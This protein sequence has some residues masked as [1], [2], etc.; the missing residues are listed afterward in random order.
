[1]FENYMHLHAAGDSWPDARKRAV[2]LHALGTEGQRLFYALPDT[3]DTYAS[4]VEGLKKHFV[5][6]VNVIAECHKFRQRAQRPEE[7]VNEF[8][9]ALRQLAV[10]CEFGDMEEP[11]LRDQLIERV[12]NTRIRDRLES[13][14]TLAKATTLALQIKTG[15]RNA[16]VLS[17]NTA[18]ATLV[19]AI[20]SQPRNNRPQQK[21]KMAPRTAPDTA[22][23]AVCRRVVTF[24]GR[25]INGEGHT[26]TTNQRNTILNHGK[27]ITVQHMLA[28]LGLTGYSRN[29]VPNYVGLTQPLRDMVSAAGN[30]NLTAA[31]IWTQEAEEAFTNTKQALSTATALAS[32]DYTAPFHLD[33]SEKSGI[34]NAVLYQQKEGERRILMYHSSRLDNMELGQGGCARHLAALAKAITKTEHMVMCHPL[35]INTNHGVVAFLNSSAFTFSTARKVK[36]SAAL[37]QPHITYHAEGINMAQNMTTE[38]HLKHD[39]AEVAAKDIRLRPDLQTEPLQAP[40]LTLYTDGRCYK[41]EN[42]NIASYA[43]VKQE[44]QHHDVID[45]GTIPQPAPAQL[46]EVIALTKALQHSKGLRVNIYTDSAYAH[47]AVHVDG[48]QWVR[49]HFLTTASTPVK[50][51]D[52]LEELI[53]AVLLPKEVAVMKCRVHQK[54]SSDVARGNE[55]ADAAAKQ[56]GGYRRQMM[57]A[58][59]TELPELT[60]KHIKEMQDEAGAYENNEWMKKGATHKE[61]LWRSHDGR[62]VAPSKL[63]QLLLKQAHGPAHE[64]KKT[65]LKNIDIL[66][67]H[68]YMTSMVDNYVNECTICT[69]HNTRLT[70][71]C[72]IGKFPVPDAPFKDITIDF[73]DMGAENRVQGYRYLLVMVDRFTKWVEAIPCRKEDAKTVVQSAEEVPETTQPK[74]PAVSVGDWVQTHSQYGSSSIVSYL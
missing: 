44:Q 27:P 42:G 13:D 57:A 60:E 19:R 40:D 3:G 54:G 53:K 63:C 46:A 47:G 26:L 7:T 33:V 2:L 68:L 38:E 69:E 16:D 21:K 22:P 52:Q 67:W 50:H 37:K 71:K 10:A 4:A 18:A 65:T 23:N 62:L 24:L 64:S 9:A 30:R 51:R 55:A 58:V 1:M 31:L 17:D 28:F 36:V 35:K 34:V 43:V 20:H 6:K 45:Q 49:R 61:G 70:Y 39:C 72:P 8:L 29:Y 48:P 11:M 56:A 66:W 14:L 25:N 73:T 41:G 15:L 5:P 32:P 74:T 12:A 59:A